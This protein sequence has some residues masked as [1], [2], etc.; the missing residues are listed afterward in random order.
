MYLFLQILFI[1]YL[2]HNLYKGCNLRNLCSWDEKAKYSLVSFFKWLARI[3]SPEPYNLYFNLLQFLTVDNI[4]TKKFKLAY[5]QLKLSLEIPHLIS[6]SSAFVQPLLASTSHDKSTF[7][8]AS[9]FPEVLMPFGQN[10]IL[11]PFWKRR[12]CHF[13]VEIVNFDWKKVV[14]MVGEVRG[15]NK[16]DPGP[17]FRGPHAFW[18]ELQLDSF[19][20]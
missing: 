7:S 4:K 15:A 18:A 1:K 12:K 5:S 20:K 19:W 10:Q 2:C 3:W 14:E 13:W 8:S 11:I 17:I 16:I 9:Q 6:L